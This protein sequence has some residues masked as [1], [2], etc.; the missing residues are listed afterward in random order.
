LPTDVPEVVVAAT[1][2][3]DRATAEK[4]PCQ[5][6]V[7]ADHAEWA[8]HYL[9]GK[10]AECTVQPLAAAAGQRSGRAAV[11]VAAK[12]PRS[13]CSWRLATLALEAGDDLRHEFSGT[14]CVLAGVGSKFLVAWLEMP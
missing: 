1:T 6:E 9:A 11:S 2:D 7:S 10:K 8:V 14:D 13:A 12:H 4:V 3:P 5:V